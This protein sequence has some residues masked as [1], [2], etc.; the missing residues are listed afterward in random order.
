MLVAFAVPAE[1]LKMLTPDK[2]LRTTGLRVGIGH[3]HLKISDLERSLAFF[4]GVIGFELTH[5]WT[6]EPAFAP[7][8][9]AR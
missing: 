6:T 7:V 3:T 2:N 9:D 1:F 5:K 8:R 4:R